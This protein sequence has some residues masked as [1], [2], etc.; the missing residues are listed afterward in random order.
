MLARRD[1]VAGHFRAT[2][3]QALNEHGIAARRAPALLVGVVPLAAVADRSAGAGVAQ[4][5]AAGVAGEDS[6]GVSAKTK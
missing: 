3:V 2:P 4:V 5:D 6:N 1:L